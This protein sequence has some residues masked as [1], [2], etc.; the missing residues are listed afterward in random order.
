MNDCDHM[1]GC[2]W[3]TLKWLAREFWRDCCNEL[4]RTARLR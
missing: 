1:R 4:R 3:R 2:V